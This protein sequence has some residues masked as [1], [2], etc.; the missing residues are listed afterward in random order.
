MKKNIALSLP[1][2]RHDDDAKRIDEA[3]AKLPGIESH[4]IDI[5]SKKV[6]L[7][8][9]ELIISLSEILKTI[10]DLK[11]D[12]PSLKRDFPIVGMS[13]ASCAG[14]VESILKL[15]PGVLTANVNFANTTASLEFIPH[16]VDL[17]S[18]KTIVQS[19]G[20][21][22]II[23]D[24]G[25]ERKEEIQNELL[26]QLKT[27]TIWAA[28]LS[29]PVVIMGMFLM[30]L[31]YANWVMMVITT[32]IVFW[33]GRSFF[34][35]AYK[36]AKHFHAN[37]D[38][39]VAISTGIAFLFSAFNTVYPE[40][41]HARGLHPHVYF[42]SAAVVIVFLMVGKL[43]E[44]NAKSNTSSAIKK[45]IS[46]QSR[47]VTII[48]NDEQLIETPIGDVKIGH[49]I[50]TRPG[51][52]IPVDGE[53]VSGSSFVNESMITGEPIPIEKNKGA[54][55]YSGTINQKGSLQIKVEKVGEGTLLSQIIKAVAIAQGSKAPI[56]KLVDR[57]A[58]IFVPVVIT[59]ALISFIA[60]I[61]WG[62]ENA[63]SYG[64]LSMITV[65]VIACPC[66][67]GLATPTALMVG[68]GKGAE[69]GILIKDAESLQLAHKV[70]VVT[71]DKT[72]TITAGTPEVIDFIWAN[73]FDK[74][75]EKLKSVLLSIELQSEHPLAEAVVRK[76][77][78]ENI[79]PISL[80]HHIQSIPGQGICAQI[81]THSYTVGSLAMM[82]DKNISIPD[83]L[84]EQAE[85]LRAKACS[86]VF[87]SRDQLVQAIISISDKIK[88]SAASAIQDLQKR[89][90]EVYMLT[91]DN[92][93]TAKSVA[94][95]VGIKSF[96]ADMSPFD[97]GKFIQ[98]LQREGK[99]VAM[100]GD[101]INDS[102]A[103]ALADV[104]IAMGSGS[105]IAMDTAKI[106][107]ISPDLRQVA[108]AL[109]LSLLTI[110]TIKQNLFWAFIYNLIGLPIAAGLLYPINGF[111]LNPMIAGA[112]MAL[113]SISVVGNSLRLKRKTL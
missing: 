33:F 89:G 70:D 99:T 112:A 22:I 26:H 24:D 104:S 15:Q 87:F 54:K 32:P 44:E 23:D 110:K 68:I 101:G 16:L 63:I 5:Y 28:L 13:C 72:G 49:L 80:H 109:R 103:L 9:D 97:K 18:L 100:V 98:Q 94:E 45:L 65:L 64:M 78:A 38:T 41:W 36:H 6:H 113:S 61:I 35:N 107:L 105:D 74:E 53:V 47:T 92:Y 106:T 20:Y 71:L 51:D 14:S 56:Q 2:L 29:I 37:M 108:R 12:V 43:L 73:D 17:N 75:K 50:L 91:G 60:W 84:S 59:I 85:L 46:L 4:E 82:N 88:E 34:V 31:P 86:V 62:E 25:K 39:L 57:V 77:T 19:I 58:G 21:D 111:L 27:K 90:I 55:V 67:L 102:E 7:Q 66:A 30:N 93:Q 40:F 69:S 52:K 3:L 10:R 48:S 8:F 83:L 81:E 76:L 95:K 96:K 1:E 79:I 42:E 11:V